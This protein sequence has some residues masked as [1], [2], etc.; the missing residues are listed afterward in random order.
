[1][2]ITDLDN[3]GATPASADVIP[4]V[5]VSD[6]TESPT[7]TTKRV[8]FGDLG[9]SEDSTFNTDTDVSGNAWVLDEDDMVSDSATKL[10]TQQSIKAY[11]DAEIAGVSAGAGLPIVKARRTAGNLTLNSTSWA[12]VDTGL[13]LVLN[14]VQ[15][16]DEIVYGISYRVSNE[17]VT[18][19]LDVATIVSGSPYR[20][21]G[22]RDA[23]EASPGDQGIIGWR[24]ESSVATSESGMAPPY[25]VVAG[26]I[27]SGSV[28][29]RL[30]Y[31]TA[32]AANRTMNG[33]STA[34]L[35]VWA[36]NLGPAQ[37]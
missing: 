20:S 37:S 12:N 36:M 25:T 35:D 27:S 22:R 1:M 23:V 18:L 17:A 9:I 29:L 10:A 33:A 16:G 7:G 4:I 34:P 13:D 21:L 14:E 30:R 2:K 31:A 26:D 6:T 24:A 8:T 11:I 19:Y 5:D 3:L 28:T 15:E 32:S